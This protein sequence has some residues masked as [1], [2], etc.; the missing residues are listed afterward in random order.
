[1]LTT[2]EQF[3]YEWQYG[4]LGDSFKGIL[5]KLIAK[6]D[7]GNRAKLRLA[8]PEY[9]DGVTKYQSVEGWWDN[10]QDIAEA[11]YGK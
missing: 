5:A 7:T 10:V 11:Q 1:M 4:M 2:E 6:S 8:F 3:V 9:V